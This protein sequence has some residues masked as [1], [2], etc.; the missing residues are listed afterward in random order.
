MISPSTLHVTLF[1]L[2]EKPEGMDK[3]AYTQKAKETLMECRGII[4]RLVV[5]VELVEVVQINNHMQH[6]A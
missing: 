1:L 5:V 6:M 4:Q 2:E 3:E